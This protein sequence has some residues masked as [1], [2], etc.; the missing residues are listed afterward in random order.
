MPHS[1]PRDDGS[2]VIAH[3]GY[4]N[5]AISVVTVGLTGCN[6][7]TNG[8]ISRTAYPSDPVLGQLK[9]LTK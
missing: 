3:F 8:N 1:C 9:R 4:P 5:G 7:V 6:N 2:Q